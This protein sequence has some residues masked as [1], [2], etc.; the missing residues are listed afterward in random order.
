VPERFRRN[1]PGAARIP[2]RIEKTRRPAADII[3][4]ADSIPAARHD[5]ERPFASG[6]APAGG[7]DGLRER[8]RGCRGCPLWKPA[9][10][11][12]F[13]EGPQ[14]AQVMLVG[15]QPGDQEDLAGRP[16]IGPAGQMLDRALADAG[17][18]RGE[19]Y[20]TNAVKHFKFVPRGRRRLHQKP[21]SVEIRACHPWLDQEL[22]IV[23]PVLEVALGATAAHALF[24]RAMAIGANRGRVMPLGERRALVTIHPSYLLRLPSA[25][26]RR[27]EYRAFVADLRLARV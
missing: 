15:E 14:T 4:E 8:A 10:Q 7:L 17:I 24:G 22:A 27:G 6:V 2:P 23:D 20:L 1:L 5:A 3:I 12:V 19:I 13:G 21:G 26:A 9:T 16:F 11:I 25:E 18:D